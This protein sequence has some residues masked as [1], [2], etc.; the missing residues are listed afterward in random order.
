MSN[1]T[2]RLQLALQWRD[3]VASGDMIER[4]PSG[5]PQYCR[6]HLSV[7]GSVSQ[8]ELEAI[9]QAANS[10]YR[11]MRS[12]L[13]IGDSMGELIPGLAKDPRA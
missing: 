8:V 10:F 9:C 12:D 13:R 7:E 5:G 3:D 1:L 2:A 6:S 4:S 11:A